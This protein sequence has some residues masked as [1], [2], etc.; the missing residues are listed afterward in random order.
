M[1]KIKKVKSPLLEARTGYGCESVRGTASQFAA[2]CNCSP[3]RMEKGT[4]WSPLLNQGQTFQL[5]ESVWS[6]DVNRR[7]KV[8]RKNG[9]PVA[10]PGQETESRDRLVRQRSGH[11]TSASSICG[12]PWTTRFH[13]SRFISIILFSQGNKSC[14]SCFHWHYC[15]K[16]CHKCSHYKVGER[17]RARTQRFSTVA[18]QVLIVP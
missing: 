17:D 3:G 14:M 13:H 10:Y 1:L 2:G 15:S 9:K 18:E 4:P 11:H 6:T 7:R 5:E 12:S 8:E 16:H